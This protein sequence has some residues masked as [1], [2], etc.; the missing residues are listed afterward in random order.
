[1]KKKILF[2]VIIILFVFPILTI[3]ATGDEEGKLVVNGIQSVYEVSEEFLS[4]DHIINVVNAGTETVERIKIYKYDIN[5][6]IS[7]VRLQ[8][9]AADE[10]IQYNVVNDDLV[11]EVPVN[12]GPGNEKE[13]HLLYQFA[14]EGY[15]G[16]GVS[17]VKLPIPTPR[18]NL[19]EY[20]TVGNPVK[21]SIK[22]P[23]N[24]R[25]VDIFPRNFKRAQDEEGLHIYSFEMNV[26]P[27]QVTVDLLAE[28]S[29]NFTFTSNNLV[30][31][32]LIVFLLVLAGVVIKVMKKKTG[33][34]EKK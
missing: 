32:I 6:E 19:A 14:L 18:V 10:E 12:L 4:C 16:E 21:F 28:D 9:G 22:A 31:A 5:Y 34:G 8:S 27:N 25:A 24:Y 2:F 30:N 17:R 15:F 3:S 7:D 23:R 33:T 29:G 11:V 13:I 26:L 1:M 20:N